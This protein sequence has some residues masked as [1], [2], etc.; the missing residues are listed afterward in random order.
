[1]R[2]GRRLLKADRRS[3]IFCHFTH[4]LLIRRPNRDEDEQS[5]HMKMTR[6]HQGDGTKV[7]PQSP[8]R[9]D[10]R[11]LQRLST[12]LEDDVTHGEHSSIETSLPGENENISVQSQQNFPPSP[13]RKLQRPARPARKQQSGKKTFGNRKPSEPQQPAAKTLMP[14]RLPVDEL[15]L[16]PDRV[17]S[18]PICASDR[19]SKYIS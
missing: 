12:D 11:G 13:K 9:S 16:V 6:F 8:V 19:K 10:F 1:V 3:V 18:V 4:A 5:D 14:R 7:S 2:F 15:E 17:P